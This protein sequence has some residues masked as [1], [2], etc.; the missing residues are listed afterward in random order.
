[1]RGRVAGR[2]Y[3]LAL[4]ALCLAVSASSGTASTPAEPLFCGLSTT[5]AKAAA[6]FARLKSALQATSPESRFNEFVAPQ[7]TIIDA[8][9]RSL[10]F[11][12][13][14]FNSITPGRIRIEDWREISARGLA[15]VEGV[16]WRG[17][18]MSHGRV[19]FEASETQGL[20]L[21]GINRT[22]AWDPPSR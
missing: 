2:A 17:C 15:A 16:G 11:Q 20:V 8:T 9:G 1:M 7:F 13:A 6:Y 5:H 3:A 21:M 10:S 18:I 4:S 14:D 19:W 22:I 12:R